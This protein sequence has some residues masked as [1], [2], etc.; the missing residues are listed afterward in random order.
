MQLRREALSLSLL[1]NRSA[2]SRFSAERTHDRARRS[3][4]HRRP[5]R[6]H[7][8]HPVDAAVEA[9]PVPNKLIRTIL[10]AGVCALSGGNMQR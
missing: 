3:F 8:N 7:P 9:D 6:D 5:L 4:E 1:Y 10:E 2:A